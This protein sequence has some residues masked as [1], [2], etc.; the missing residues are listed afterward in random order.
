MPQRYTW[1]RVDREAKSALDNRVKTINQYD[2]KNLGINNRKIFQIDLTNFLFKQKIFISDTEL[3]QLA[4]K[5]FG[6][7]LF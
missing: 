2:L 5:K 6:K 1:I 7:R 4:K 3:K